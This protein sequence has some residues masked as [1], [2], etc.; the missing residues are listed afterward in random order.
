MAA[1]FFC[2]RRCLSTAKIGMVAVFFCRASSFIHSEDRNG[3]RFLLSGVAVY[4]QRRLERRSFSSI[5]RCR[6]STARDRKLDM[7]VVGLDRSRALARSL[8]CPPSSLCGAQHATARLMHSAKHRAWR[9]AIGIGVRCS[10]CVAVDLCAPKRFAP[11]DEVI[12]ICIGDMRVDSDTCCPRDA[13]RQRLRSDFSTATMCC[14]TRSQW[15]CHG[16]TVR[17]TLAGRTGFR[18]WAAAAAPPKI[19]ANR[20]VRSDACG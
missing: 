12:H 17:H 5:G 19:E 13:G 15:I 8:Q 16:E 2:R 20:R 11:P 14:A 9:R 4:P 10:A 18:L 3:G 6:L 1:V 7:C